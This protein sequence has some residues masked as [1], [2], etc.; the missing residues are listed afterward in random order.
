MCMNKSSEHTVPTNNS[1]S[2][3]EHN[4]KHNV[5]TEDNVCFF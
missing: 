1:S 2:G 5:T 3:M 4:L